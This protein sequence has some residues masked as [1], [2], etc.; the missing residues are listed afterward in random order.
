MRFCIASTKG[1]TKMTNTQI[2]AMIRHGKPHRQAYRIIKSSSAITNEPIWMILDRWGTTCGLFDDQGEAH[3]AVQ[4][5]I[6]ED[7]D[8][9]SRFD[10]Y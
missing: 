6:A 4:Q 3:R 5:Y 9:G 8:L 10:G 1:T 2:L 7:A